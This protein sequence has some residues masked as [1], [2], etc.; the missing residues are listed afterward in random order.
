M[1][2]PGAAF[3]DPGSPTGDTEA[4]LYGT[5]AATAVSGDYIVVLKDG[6]QATSAD[7]SVQEAQ[8]LGA[9]VKY[10][11][12]S[13]LQGFAATLSPDALAQ[14][15]R[16]PNVAFVEA[17]STVVASATQP[18]PPSWGLDRIDQ[19]NLPLNSS[20]TYNFTGAGVNVYIIDT[21]IRASH[22][23][24]AGRIGAGF[25][26]VDGG[27]P[28]DCNGHGTHV[29]GTV[30]GTSYG[31]AKQAT[32]H[33]VRVLDCGG[34][35]TNA[36]VIA[37]IDWVTANR[38]SPAVANMSLGGSASTS[39]D[40]AVTNSINAGVTYA[41][42]AGN[43]STNAC[44]RSPARTPAAITVGATGQ[45]DARASFSNFGTCLDIFAPGV[46]I[47]SAWIGSNTATNTISGTSMASPHVAG[48]AALYLDENSSATPQQVRDA[49]VANGT[50]GVVGSPGTGSPNVLLHSLFGA[51]P[52]PPPPGG[53][54]ENPT[55]VPIPD[56]GTVESS[57]AT[58]ELGNAP[59]DLQVHV[60]ILHTYRGDLRIDLVAP[61]GTAYRVKNSSGS[62]GAD[63]V[64]A[65]YT[66]N[67]SSE[68]GTG[69]W[70]LRVRDVYAADTGFI[71]KWS[72]Q[73]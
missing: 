23:D 43:E 19:R 61:D 51:A 6:L 40:N 73:F 35:G 4:P 49:I 39:L 55:D 32:I 45:N 47:T 41:V 56:L 42:A 62:D 22:Q 36:G 26:A 58:A 2:L 20:Y 63:N 18:N 31:V 67:A 65:T 71:D 57:L 69:T 34:S 28:D 60:E 1:G 50:T 10:E 68:A 38:V 24:F 52:P 44:T 25:D 15:R 17:D 14:V 13:A 37:G 16:D 9:V 11:Y 27:A 54:Y 53:F 21:G 12:T 30:A 5:E 70:K 33:A 48:V 7:A 8:A 3:A 29:A 64:I 72:L 66:V 59:A 46:G